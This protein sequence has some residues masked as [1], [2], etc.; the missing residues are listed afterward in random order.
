[1]QHRAVA[2]A[3]TP[4]AGDIRHGDAT[5]SV[6]DHQSENP[7]QGYQLVLLR[8]ELSFSPRSGGRTKREKTAIS[9]ERLR[10]LKGAFDGEQPPGQLLSA[11]S[12]PGR[13]PSFRARRRR[14]QADQGADDQK[15]REKSVFRIVHGT[16]CTEGEKDVPARNGTAPRR[17][18][19]SRRRPLR[20]DQKT[21]A[22]SAESS[23]QEQQR[24]KPLIGRRTDA[25]RPISGSS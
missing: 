8:T 5:L 23:R 15:N 12:A 6:F 7:P 21:K 3:R 18:A 17:T 25:P 20:N 14:G 24:C 19:S 2:P 4:Q 11:V 22:P 13:W 9:A 10:H 1:M 16:C